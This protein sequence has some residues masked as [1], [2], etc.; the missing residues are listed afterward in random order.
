MD[1]Y[2][3]EQMKENDENQSNSTVAVLS[4]SSE[5]HNLPRSQFCFEKKQEYKLIQE[6]PNTALRPW[7]KR[8]EYLPQMLQL[9]V[10]VCKLFSIDT[11]PT[12]T[13][14]TGKIYKVSYTQC[15]TM[16]RQYEFTIPNKQRVFGKSEHRLGARSSTNPLLNG[17]KLTSTLTHKPWNDS[18]E[19][20]SLEMQ[21]LAWLA[22][23]LF[24]VE[25]RYSGIP[26]SKIW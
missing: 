16:R 15:P 8:D 9:K 7:A 1:W 3:G 14:S 6:C 4:S 10:F 2:C 25:E 24:I 22:Q 12:C 20:G 21:Q 23:S 18:M 13:I 11:F 17:S 5:K 19:C 26:A